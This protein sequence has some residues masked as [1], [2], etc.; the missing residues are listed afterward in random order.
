MYLVSPTLL[1]S[2]QYYVSL[3]P[4]DSEAVTADEKEAQARAEFLA[5]LGKE[6]FERSEAMQLG[7]DFED[8]IAAYCRGA[9]NDNLCV[10]EIGDI[11][12]GGLWQQTVKAELDGFLLYGRMDV[13]KRDTIYDI[14]RTKSYDIG[15]YQKS[16]Q[17]RIY[18]Y[19]SKMPKFSYLVSDERSVWR[20]DYYN[21]A[22]I[23]GEIQ[24]MIRQFTGYLE[25][26][27][28]AKQRYYD[29]WKSKYA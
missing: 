3:D 10:R 15:K 26:D 1:N 16:A 8:A 19:C 7:I 25:N 20:E 9:E 5:M 18:L 28:E 2:W 13:I 23:K 17:H 4:E 6:P 24:D 14:K 11:V 21:H 27:P 12:K 22:G 29:L